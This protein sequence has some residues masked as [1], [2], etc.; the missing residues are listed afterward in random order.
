MLP[1]AWRGSATQCA[2]SGLFGLTRSLALE[3]A[4]DGVRVNAVSPGWTRTQLVQDYFRMQPDPSA[5]ETDVLAAHP[6]GRTCEP[7]GVA[8]V[9][10][11]LLSP[12][13]RGMTGAEVPVDGGL[14]IRF[15]D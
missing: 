8:A 13:A 3:L 11:F 2:K 15:A 4:P 10:A 1:S 12:A 5:A 14:G 6:L 9:V 7:S